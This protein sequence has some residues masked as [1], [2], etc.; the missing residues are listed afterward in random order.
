MACLLSHRTSSTSGGEVTQRPS[1]ARTPVTGSV[2]L[3]LFRP[4]SQYR[5]GRGGARVQGTRARGGAPRVWA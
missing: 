5:P 4:D 3:N 2:F 1:W